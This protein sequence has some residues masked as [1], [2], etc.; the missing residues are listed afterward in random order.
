[1]ASDKVKVNRTSKFSVLDPR[2][3]KVKHILEDA[4]KSPKQGKRDKT[5]LTESTSKLIEEDKGHIGGEF[6]LQPNP[7]FLAERAKKFDAAAA[8]QAARL[9]EK[10]RVTISVML[11]DGTEREGVS[12]ETTPMDIAK[13]ISKNL[14]KEVLVAEIRYKNRIDDDETN[15]SSADGWGEEEEEEEGKEGAGAGAGGDGDLGPPELWDLLRPLIGSCQIRLLKFDDNQ[16]KTVF[17]HSSAHCLGMAMEKKY[18]CHLTHG[19]PVENGFF[20][21]CFMGKRAIREEDLKDL[22]KEVVKCAKAKQTF[23]RLLISKEEALDM[24][25]YNVFKREYIK[26]KIPDG[27]CTTVYRNGDFIDLCRGPHVP[28]STMIQ[29]FKSTRASATNWLGKVS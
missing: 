2:A 21:D 14:A 4:G 29:S 11:P 13:G 26:T 27:G 9:K 24:F 20:Y 25:E 19:P 15:V 23:N 3:S 28:F 10:P 1:M 16:A 22:N 12:Y 7:S 8:K 6:A 5:R 17:W 18:G